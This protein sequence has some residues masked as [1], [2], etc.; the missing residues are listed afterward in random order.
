MIVVTEVVLEPGFDFVEPHA[1]LELVPVGVVA[2]QQRFELVED[3]VIV[4]DSSDPVDPGYY[5][6]PELEQLPVAASPSAA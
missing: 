6:H 2:A 4:A 1:L 3:S 5:F